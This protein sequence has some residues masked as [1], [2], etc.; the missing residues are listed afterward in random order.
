MI[1][2]DNA[3][4]SRFKPSVTLNAVM[5]ELTSSANPGRG[6]HNDSIKSG[7][8][9]FSARM[10]IKEFFNADDKYE[11][12]FTKNCTEALNLAIRGY[13]SSFAGKVHVITSQLEHNSILR[14][15]F[16]LE[17]RGKI[18]LS[19]VEYTHN[20]EISISSI[21]K[22]IRRNT[23][24]VALAHMSNVIG[25]HID[26]KS[27]SNYLMKRRIPLLIDGAQSVGHIA[28]D[29]SESPISMLA[30]AGHKGLYGVQGTGFLIFDRESV[31]LSPIT[32]GGTGTNSQSLFQPDDIPE[33]YESGTL[34]TAGI[35]GLSKS[36]SWVKDN[37][38]EINKKIYKISTYIYNTLYE[39]ESI[40][41]YTPYPSPVI[42][43]NVSGL[44]SIEVANYLNEKDIAVRAGLHCAPL[45]HK[46]LGTFEKGAVRVSIG[47]S[48][49]IEEAE[50]LIDT[51]KEILHEMQK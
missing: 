42:S 16:E 34:N 17:K 43:F 26:V 9:V 37:F 15:L 32:F 47:Y 51:I 45:T 31:R 44:D 1:Y 6:G 35:A 38:G 39:L 5:E 12:I 21:E 22:I 7:E 20:Y 10:N 14:I 27:I 4:T 8:K 11:V 24:L 3:A 28:I 46:L 33:R 23:V 49:T 13:L 36:V 30:S 40:E 41:L 2:F 25:N 50:Y 29:F 48:N 18:S 19:F